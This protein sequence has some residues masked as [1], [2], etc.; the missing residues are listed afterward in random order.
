M[1]IELVPL[2]PPTS[3][4]PSILSEF[5]REVKR[6]NPATLTQGEFEEVLEALYKYSILLFRNVSLTPEEQ[7]D[8]TKA[9]DPASN[10]Y[11]HRN[12]PGNTSKAIDIFGLK[13]IP[14][15]PT[16]QLIGNGT[17]FN[18]EGIEKV[19]LKH[20]SHTK[21]HKTPV[22]AIDEAKGITRFCRWHM[23]AALYDLSPPKVTSLYGLVV[24]QGEPQVVRYDDGTGDELP[25]SL[26]TTA[27][28]SGH[29][30]FNILP[31]HFKSLAVRSRVKYAPHMFVWMSPAHITSTG[32]GIESEGL[33]MPLDE[34]PEWE[35]AKCKT[36]P[37]LWKNEATGKLHFQVHPCG[38]TELLVDPLP[39]GANREGALYPDGTHL[40]DLREVREVLYKMQRP[41]IAPKHAYPHDW[42]E[43]DLIL[44]HNRGVMHSVVGA[45]TK[46][47]IRVFHQCNFSGSDDPL[48]PSTTDVKN[49]A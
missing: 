40:T 27:F 10:G 30:M 4:D 36:L 41:A 6:L 32:L 37:V 42:R 7:H 12:E 16:V 38:V 15:I 47:Q 43:N 22:S 18:H 3:F 25:V 39:A 17:V 5:G 49:W 11:A 14:R 46:D 24:P 35:D 31:P 33:E 29:V 34:L 2:P 13:T 45:L 26:G 44:F 19:E 28:V 1:T 8:L 21:F 9:F 20:P 23:D 48:G